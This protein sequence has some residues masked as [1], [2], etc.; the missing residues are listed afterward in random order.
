[1]EPVA[2]AT[3][4]FCV[5]GGFGKDGKEGLQKV[6]SDWRVQVTKE[7][8][9]TREGGGRGRFPV[10]GG[11]REQ[12]SKPVPGG[13]GEGW[14]SRKDFV[15]SRFVECKMYP[16]EWTRNQSFLYPKHLLRPKISTCIF[17]SQTIQN[18]QKLNCLAAP[19]F[20]HKQMPTADFRFFDCV[21]YLNQGNGGLL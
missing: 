19:C 10:S 1:M 9:G 6:S 11:C 14:V 12:K 4:S 18:E 13:G 5:Q 16:I 21:L 3:G 20:K 17:F 8:A 7:Q 2:G 15:T